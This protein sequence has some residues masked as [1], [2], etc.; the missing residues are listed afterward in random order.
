[1]S[2]KDLFIRLTYNMQNHAIISRVKMVMVL[3]PIG[4]LDM[5]FNVSNP[6]YSIHTKMDIGKIRSCIDIVLTKANNLNRKPIGSGLL[7]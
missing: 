7:A 5:N 4:R 6:L 3:V 1:M 2:V